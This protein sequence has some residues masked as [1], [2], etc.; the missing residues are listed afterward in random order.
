MSGLTRLCARACWPR[1]RPHPDPPFRQWPAS[2]Q[3][4]QSWFRRRR[5]PAKPIHKD[6]LVACIMRIVPPFQGSRPVGDYTGDLVVNLR[7]QRPSKSAAPGT[8]Q[9]ASEYQM[10]ELLS[11]RKGNDAD[12]GNVPSHHLYGGMDEARKKKSTSS[13]ASCA[14][15]WPTPHRG[16]EWISRRSGVAAMFLRRAQRKRGA[17]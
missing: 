5:H 10:L 6:E 15:S 14:R 2:R 16:Q 1:S 12:Q 7:H 11:L 13:S 3:G 4:A 17:P 8:S 9:R